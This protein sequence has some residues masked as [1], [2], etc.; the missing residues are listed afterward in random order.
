M[1]NGLGYVF[2]I[3]VRLP[4]DGQVSSMVSTQEVKDSSA[5]GR[6]QLPHLECL[7]L[8]LG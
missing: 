2:G 5:L 1:T 6:R 8:G 3:R 4:V 7:W